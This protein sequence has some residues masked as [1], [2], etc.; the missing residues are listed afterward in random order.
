[1]FAGLCAVKRYIFFYFHTIKNNLEKLK[2]SLNMAFFLFFKC[3]FGLYIIPSRAHVRWWWV[4]I[5]EYYSKLKNLIFRQYV[6]YYHIIIHI[7]WTYPW[8]HCEYRMKC[9]GIII[10]LPG[11]SVVVKKSSVTSECQCVMSTPSSYHSGQKSKINV[12]AF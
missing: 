1:M 3:I 4:Q 11:H 7:I 12:H 9:F 10:L 5:Y 8:G 2:M 6:S